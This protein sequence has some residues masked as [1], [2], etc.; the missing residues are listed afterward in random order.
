MS[1]QQWG[2]GFHAGYNKALQELKGV[3]HLSATRQNLMLCW[4]PGTNEVAIFEHPDIYGKTSKYAYWTMLGQS[5]MAEKKGKTVEA[6]K[7]MIFI[8]AMHLIIRDACDPSAVHN[9]LINVEEYRDG[10]SDDM[11]TSV[12]DW[13]AR[14]EKL[15]DLFTN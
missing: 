12:D 14:R 2:H 13:F 15:K 10:C 9:A 7:T 5:S 8:E 11:L 4:N 1:R 3:Q 6:V